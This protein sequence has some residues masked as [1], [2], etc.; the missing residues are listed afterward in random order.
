MVH[1]AL[2]A[3]LETNRGLITETCSSMLPKGKMINLQCRNVKSYQ[4]DSRILKQQKR[5]E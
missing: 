5:K 3:L 4:H 1:Y 2:G